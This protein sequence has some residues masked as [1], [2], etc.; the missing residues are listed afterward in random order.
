MAVASFLPPA[1]R[2][3]AMTGWIGVLPLLGVLVLQVL[4][5]VRLNSTAFQDEALY[6]T[7]GHWLRNGTA[8]SDPSTYFSGA[9]QLYPVFASYLD[10][11][12]GLTLVR[13]FSTACMVSSTVAVYWATTVLFAHRGKAQRTGL[14]AALVFSLSTPVMF[15]GHFGTFDAPSFTLIAWGLALAVWSSKR[16]RS[17]AWGA[18]IGGFV[19]FAV[20]LKYSAAIDAP[21][22]LLLTLTGWNVRAQRVRTLLRGF[23]A[24]AVALGMLAGAAA[25]PWGK[26]DLKGLA[27]STTARNLGGRTGEALLIKNVFTW[28]GV[29]ISVMLLGGLYLLRRQPILATLLVGGLLAATAYQ[30][31][32][33]EL[34]SLHKHIALGLVI[35][36]PLGGLLLSDLCNKIKPFGLLAA[37][38]LVWI[39]F[40]SSLSQS[41]HLYAAWSNTQGLAQTLDYS[42]KAMPW[43]RTVGDTPE[44]MEYAFIDKAKSW[45]FTGTYAGSFYYQ[46]LSDEPAYEAALQ[47]NYFQVAYLDGST[48]ISRAL[49]SKMG[50]FGFKKTQEVVAPNGHVWHIW[51]RFDKI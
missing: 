47:D 23:L 25:S 9:P 39:A 5:S 41:A 33:G 35:G 28:S 48:P 43:L 37:G 34:T 11:L 8:Y 21:F 51:Q 42:F 38:A 12:G 36:A 44:P 18:L 31:H 24:G 26:G 19:A 46:N 7:I 10:S 6:V 13:L 32:M 20:M 29:T 15:L 30:I 14:L 45:Q 17:L 16:N 49:M 4:T 3:Q 1:K 2:D 50:S 40:L 22:V 27:F